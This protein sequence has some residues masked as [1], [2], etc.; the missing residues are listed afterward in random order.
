MGE[1]RLALR[2]FARRRMALA[3]TFFLT[4]LILGA[5]AAPLV[6]PYDPLRQDLARMLAGP[7][8]AH[9]LGTDDLGRDVLT[10]VL[11]GARLSL[12]AACLAVAIATLA[13]VPI[14]LV[15]G[16]LGGRIDDVLMRVIDALQAFPALILAMAI[17]AALGPGLFNVMVAV[18]VVYTPRFARLVRG[19]VLALRE[20]PF[21]ESARAAGATHARVLARHVLPNVVA[22]IVVQVSIGVA[23]AL[24]AETALS[25]LGVGIKPPEP[26][27]GTDVGRGYRFMRLAPW[28]VFMPGTAILLTALAFN[29][30]GD[31]IRDA[32]DPR[33][34]RES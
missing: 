19:Q 34:S 13:G 25:F 28:L 24:L 4:L 2:R 32:F 11:Y 5:L 31:G 12:G 20:E 9:L 27:W 21:V 6:S 8:P 17:A 29:L 15:A 10:R 30:V 26:S 14:G 23:F 22:P 3:G 16:Y 33:Q 1:T 7:S 18:G